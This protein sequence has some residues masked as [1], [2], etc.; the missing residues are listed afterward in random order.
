VAVAMAKLPKGAAVW[1]CGPTEGSA[2][3][4]RIGIESGSDLVRTD[5]RWEMTTRPH[6]SV[7]QGGG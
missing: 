6:L 1:A 5:R 2:A 3:R 4:S 7:A